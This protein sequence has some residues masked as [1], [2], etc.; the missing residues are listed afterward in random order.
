[1]TGVGVD[2]D[3][4]DRWIREFAALI[5]AN[6]E[7]LTRLDSAIGDA[8]HGSNMDRGM[9]AVVTALD[10]S[11][12]ASAAALL[13]QV[14]MTLVSTVGGA[15]GPL[16]GTFF[17]RMATASGEV[18]SLDGPAFAK[19]LRAGLDGVVARGKAEAGDK[20]MYDALAPAVDA[21][22]AALAADPA[23]DPALGAAVRAAEDG[24]DATIP[25]LARKGRASYLGERSVDHQDP[26]A[27]SAALLIAAAATALGGAGLR[28]PAVAD[29]GPQPTGP[30]GLVV[31]SHSRALA[32]AAVALAEEMLHG[33][34]VPIEIAAGLDDSTFGTDAGQIVAAITAAD[35]GAGVVVLMD[36]GSAVLSAELALELLD[37][38]DGID[39]PDDS[40]ERA[41]NRV[42]L[43]PAP[44]VEGLIV[45]AVAAA[46]GADR[47]Q[48]AAEAGA[49][50]DGKAAALGP[51]TAGAGPSDDPGATEPGE[52]VG[53]FTVTNPHGLH[54]RPASRVVQAVAPVRRAGGAAQPHDRLG[55]GA[56]VEPDEGGHARRAARPRGRGPG[57]RRAATGGARPPGRAGGAGLRRG[58]GSPAEPRVRASDAS[59]RPDRPDRPGR[60]GPIGASPGIG[61]GPASA[62]HTAPIDVANGSADDPATEWRRL[63]E[64]ITTVRGTVERV[65]AGAVAEVG[66]AEAAIFDAHLLLLDDTDLLDEVRSRVDSGQS[67]P[68][69]WS[70]TVGRVGAELGALAD[71]Y[72]RARAADVAAV[73]NQVL[74]ALLGLA[75]GAA[76]PS[77]VLVTA[78]LTPAEAA[79]LDRSRVAAVVQAFGSPLAHSTIL[80]RARGIP[81]VVAA[82]EG[83]LDIPDGTL[84]AV[85]GTSGE[86]VADPPP[87]VQAV[88]RDRSAAFGRRERAALAGATSAAVTRDGVE[89]LVGANV[90]S[91]G[92]AAMAADCGAD[93]AG[94]VRTEFLFLD[95][96]RAPDVDEQEAAYRQIAAA[97]DGRRLTLRTLDVGGDKPLG[98]LP[99]P[100]ETNPFLGAPGHPARA[101]A[102]RAARR[103]AA[104]HGAGRARRSGERDVPD[105]QHAERAARR[106]SDA[107]RRRHAGRSR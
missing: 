47:E 25:M 89:V 36:L 100:A 69:A 68:A 24:R 45:A 52:L 54:A 15:S 104:G 1:M 6:K 84:L 7:L 53:A 9:T 76:A 107:R 32:A 46:G 34:R 43:C 11:S 70:A 64:A 71:P 86:V 21:L 35:G 90:G 17:L 92:D 23:L 82:G 63:E 99:M 101:G 96:T 105:D 77:G 41:R 39:G 78:D 22:D 3:A 56:G 75:D 28:R 72:L 27:T 19:A 67:A 55:L 94:L 59:D 31:V 42:L 48:V 57:L 79:G 20:T 95:R 51:S 97:L 60:P 91:V 81:A 62:L 2:V 40:D 13:K 83:V 88:F 37:D 66:E 10:G 4:L 102:S 26:G 80:L 33:S 49:A 5:A 12:P 65:R 73:G 16:Y 30:V 106:P 98:Y 85:D 44:L 14:G 18:T 61:S 38:A 8:D 93:L 50:L 87:D 29:P 58:R 103:A 74:R